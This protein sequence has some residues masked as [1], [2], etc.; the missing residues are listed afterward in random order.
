ML[1][2][3]RNIF[4]YPD[5]VLLPYYK[6]PTFSTGISLKYRQRLQI[7]MFDFLYFWWKRLRIFLIFPRKLL[8][9]WQV[10]NCFATFVTYG[11]LTVL[12]SRTSSLGR[13]AKIILIVLRKIVSCSIAN[14]FAETIKLY[15]ILD[16]VLLPYLYSI[17]GS[18]MFIP[19]PHFSVPDPG[20]G[21]T[22]NKWFLSTNIIRFVH[23]GSGSRFFI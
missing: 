22:Q 13:Q 18:G 23:P 20:S 15:Q 4:L 17:A 1:I 21:L 11:Y 16:F 7:N 8:I 6:F 9:T 5:F 14:I 2:F 19:D 3:L 10:R 12:I